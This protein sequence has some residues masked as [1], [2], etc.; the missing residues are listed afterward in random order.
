MAGGTL[1]KIG[2][3]MPEQNVDRVGALKMM[4][5]ACQQDGAYSSVLPPSTVCNCY[6]NFSTF[7]E[8]KSRRGLLC[9]FLSTQHEVILPY[10]V[11]AN[12]T[13]CL[14]R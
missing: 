14:C 7:G 8:V 6:R 4:S 9:P 10:I 11:H 3:T 2:C 1:G 12:E 5:F 13:T